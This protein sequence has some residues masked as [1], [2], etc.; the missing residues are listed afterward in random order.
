MKQILTSVVIPWLP[1]VKECLFKSQSAFYLNLQ[2][3]LRVENN[4]AE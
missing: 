2:L 4:E 1:F 3:E